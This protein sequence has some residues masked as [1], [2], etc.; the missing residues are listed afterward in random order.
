MVLSDSCFHKPSMEQIL[1][2]EA[3]IGKGTAHRVKD[4]FFQS[5]TT[6]AKKCYHQSRRHRIHVAG[7]WVGPQFQHLLQQYHIYTK[8]KEEFLR[9]N[10][11]LAKRKA[12]QTY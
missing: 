7:E 1:I 12:G 4:S 8:M 5:L 3:V 9:E 11:C 10:P 6:E 2:D